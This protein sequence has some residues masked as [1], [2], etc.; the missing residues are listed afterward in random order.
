MSYLKRGTYCTKTYKCNM[1]NW[2]VR[3]LFNHGM[4]SKNSPST[5]ADL[6]E[7][8][9]VNLKNQR[10]AKEKVEAIVQKDKRRGKI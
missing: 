6:P 2:F 10:T 8:S 7:T 3:F 1:Q 9:I 4:N 5:F